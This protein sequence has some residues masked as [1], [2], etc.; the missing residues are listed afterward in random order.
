MQLSIELVDLVLVVLALPVLPLHRLLLRFLFQNNLHR[1]CLF[2]KRRHVHLS[3]GFLHLAY[4]FRHS[5]LCQ[6]QSFFYINVA[7]LSI[8]L[9]VLD[10]FY[11]LGGEGRVESIMFAWD[12]NRNGFY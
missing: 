8:L 10:C 6:L 5:C 12:F 9:L 7:F 2:Q 1:L 4:K 11:L 3:S